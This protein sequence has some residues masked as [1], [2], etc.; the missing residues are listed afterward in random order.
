MQRV[1]FAASTTA[2][3]L[4]LTLVFAASSQASQLPTLKLALSKHRIT[5]SGQMVSGAVDVATTVSGEPMDN[6]TLVHLR[7]GV[8]ATEFGKKLA[9]L[10]EQTDLDVIDRYGT[11]VL[12]GQDAHAGTVTHTDAD[13]PA[14]NY[15]ALND[16][17]GHA[18]FSITQSSSPAKLPKPQATVGTIEF[19]FTGPTTLHDGELVRFKNH[20]YLIHMVQAAQVASTESATEAEDDLHNGDLNAAKK[21][22]IAAPAMWSGPLSSGASQEYVF[23]APPGV[24]VVL[25][26]MNTQDGREHYQ[27][28]MTRTIT[29]VR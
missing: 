11:I 12:D 28:G 19:G 22:A 23:N 29:V 21:L 4:G 9:G 3:V 5:V 18:V 10:S 7:P 24:Y 2:A 16:G 15:V 26:S 14:G 6:A 27:L 8:T 1:K 13:L 20:G 25:C 17:N